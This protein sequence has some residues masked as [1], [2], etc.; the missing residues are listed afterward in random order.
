MV[1]ICSDLQQQN[2]NE[3][4]RRTDSKKKY[5]YA[6]ERHWKRKNDTTKARTM[7]QRT[8]WKAGGTK[9]RRWRWWQATKRNKI[10]NINRNFLN[11]DNFSHYICLCNLKLALAY[12]LN[13][14]VPSIYTHFYSVIAWF[15]LALAFFLHF[16]YFLHAILCLSLAFCC[17]CFIFHLCVC[18]ARI[19]R[20]HRITGIELKLVNRQSRIQCAGRTYTPHTQMTKTYTYSRSKSN[21]WTNVSR[22]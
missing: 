9:R 19:L 8:S 17:C 16:H 7:I 1:F 12:T 22:K 20:Q 10:Y 13:A 18:A 15:F 5:V 6:R 4:E 3:T 11:M 21:E 2:Q 14:F